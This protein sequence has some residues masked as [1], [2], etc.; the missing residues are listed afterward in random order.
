MLLKKMTGTFT[1]KGLSF[2]FVIAPT[3]IIT[4]GSFHTHLVPSTSV[5]FPALQGWFTFV[6]KTF[7]Y[8]IRFIGSSLQVMR[9]SKSCKKSYKGT[10]G[11]CGTYGSVKVT[12]G[13]YNSDFFQ[14]RL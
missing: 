3:G 12:V 1:I 7:T 10:K 11:Y 2:K 9:F 14:C 4:I 5:S 6:Y 8:Y 13:R